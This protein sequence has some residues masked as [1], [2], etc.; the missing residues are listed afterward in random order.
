MTD[1]SPNSP[2][3]PKDIIDN[4]EDIGEVAQAPLMIHKQFL[5]DLSFENPNAPEVFF[6]EQQRPVMDMNIGIDVQRL[7]ND[8]HDYYY[9]VSLQVTANATQNGKAMFLCEVTYSAVVSINNMDEKHHQALLFVEVPQLIFPYARQ[10]ISNV[11][12]SGAFMPLQLAPVD[13]RSMFI[14]RFGKNKENTKNT[15]NTE[16]AA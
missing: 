8:K 1:T 4:D 6:G 7:E 11:S 9:E 3:S 15:E 16:N 12:Q 14:K 2:N 5:K 13:F 10:I